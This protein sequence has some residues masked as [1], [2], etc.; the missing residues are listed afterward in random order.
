MALENIKSNC[1]ASD[2][3]LYGS[4][5]HKQETL[6]LLKSL[7][8]ADRKVFLKIERLSISS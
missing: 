6:L 8:S 3:V 5:N 7:G 4:C 1:V 2:L